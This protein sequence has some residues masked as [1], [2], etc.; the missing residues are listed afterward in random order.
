MRTNWN[1]VN[2]ENRESSFLKLVEK[3]DKAKNKPTRYKGTIETMLLEFFGKT[4]KKRYTWKREIFKRLLIHTYNQKCFALLRDYKSVEVLHN[5][6]A[7][8]NQLVREVESWKRQSFDK[9]EQLRSLIRHSFALYETPIFLE[10]TFFGVDKKY[11]LWYIQLG[12]G[13][14][15]KDLSQI[16]VNLT[17][18]MAHEFKNAPAF[19]EPNQALRYAQ[20][21]G[22]AAS[23]KTAKTIGFSELARINKSE[24]KFWV[25]VVQF[26][27]KETEVKAK[28][29]NTILGYLMF[30]Y[31]ENKLFSM[32]G[33]TLNTLLQ[34]ATEWQRNVY[35]NEI[36][37]VLYWEKSGIAPLYKEQIE[38]GKKVVYKTV[39]L[40]N[41]MA[42]YDEGNV[43]HHCIA[44]YDEDC[45]DGLS[46]IFSLRKSIG[47]EISTPLATIEVGLSEMTIIEAKAKFNQEPDNKSLELI[48]LWVKNSEIKGGYEVAEYEIENN[49]VAI[50]N[51]QYTTADDYDVDKVVRVIF[52]IL[53]FIIKAIL[54]SR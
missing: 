42:L 6:S 23:L 41:S 15:I 4:S 27:A 50:E 22:F 16:P 25:T 24:E 32:K 2:I 31:G 43:M 26:F 17:N 52:W 21:L 36:G 18:R 35:K 3:I 45:K 33:R 39:E 8:G 48:D 11:M 29:L 49:A 14:S 38:N 12:K 51:R 19:F 54:L 10:N 34:L 1:T 20:A 46:T 53:Y 28:D 40:L 37:E 44:G 47:N 5:I 7:F 13:K 30:R 9:E